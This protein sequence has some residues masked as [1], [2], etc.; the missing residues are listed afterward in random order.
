[1]PGRDEPVS[2]AASHESRSPICQLPRDTATRS[3]GATASSRTPI[4][5]ARS[6]RFAHALRARGLGCRSERDALEPWES[7]QDHVA[8]Y[9]YNC[10]EYLEAMYG[11]YSARATAVNIN[12]RYTA[13]ELRYLLADSGAHARSSTTARSRRRWR[14]SVTS[15]PSSKHFIQVADES[16]ERA[17]AGC[18]RVRGASSAPRPRDPPRLPYTADDL[19]VLYTGGT[20]G[21]PKGVLWRHEDVFY[22]GLGGHVPGFQRLETEDQ[23]RAHVELGIGGR[24]LICLPFMHGAGQWSAF[25]TFPSRRDG[26]PARR[27]PPARRA[28]GLAGGRAPRRRSDRHRRRRVRA[29]ADRGAARG[30]VRPLLAA[31]GREHG[32]GPV[33]RRQGG[34]AR[35]AL[36]GNDADREHRRLGAGHAGDELRHRVGAGGSARLS[37]SRRVRCSSRRT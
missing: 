28:R 6:R 21:M 5:A 14:R 35:R 37:A 26:R 8:I 16:G 12:Y 15:C 20:T 10:P 1:M 27:D 9:L 17:A 18:R 3:C 31:R 25:N 7:G 22:N 24:A 30:R 23:L 11:A 2:V 34:A 32:G 36:A 19:Y 4:C 33:A 29:S 13:D